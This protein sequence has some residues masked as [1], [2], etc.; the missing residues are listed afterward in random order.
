MQLPPHAHDVFQKVHDMLGLCY[1]VGGCVRDVLH[2][3]NP[4]D[5]DFTCPLLPD[6]IEEK[7][8][9]NGLKPFL[10]GKKFGTVGFK[11]DGH[12]VEV[13][14]FRTEKYDGRTRYP[15][16]EFVDDI[17][18]DLAR[19]DFTINAI[20][21]RLD[22]SLIDPF[23]GQT[24]LENKVIRAVGA[25]GDRYYED[26]LRMLRAGRFA[27][28][29]GFEI[30]EQTFA[31]ADHH[32]DRILAVSKERW[33]TE[34]DKLLVAPHADYGLHYL[35]KTN[36]LNYMIPEMAIQVGYDQDSP[37]HE[38]DLFEHSVKTVMLSEP[39]TYVRWA[40]WLHDIGKPFV[41]VQNRQG[42]SNYPDHAVVGAE[43]VLKVGPYLKWSSE[44]TKEVYELVL[45]HLENGSPIEEADS[46]ARYE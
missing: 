13:T 15:V 12:H 26:P 43:L 14:T 25:P 22:G 36:L 21:M 3:R 33:V 44:R 35:A 40:A 38:L 6:E 16:V 19:R 5:L 45:K 9:S 2:G 30:E 28:Q 8:R 39:S 41:R 10:L 4:S 29:L 17:N 11:L 32:A 27:S 42:Y 31:S 37:Y 1:L 34:L 23:D 46:Q 7:V 18:H 24:D 20:A